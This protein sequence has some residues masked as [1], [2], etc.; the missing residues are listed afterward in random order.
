MQDQEKSETLSNQMQELD[1]KIQN[2]DS[3]INQTESAL[4]DVRKL[5]SQI[6][7]KSGERKSKF[8]EL[9][10]RYAALSEENE[11]QLNCS[12]LVS[13]FLVIFDLCTIY[14]FYRH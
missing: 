4:K 9:Q 13:S 14:F 5:Q 1:R 8:E 12:N 11:G 3:E 2:V 7:T 6:A 10:K